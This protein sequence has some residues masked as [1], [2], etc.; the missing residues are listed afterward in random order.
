MKICVAGEGAFGNKHLEAL[1][2]IDGVEVASLVGGVADATEAVAKKYNIPHW[3]LDLAEGLAQPG[4]E[5][6]ILTTPTPLHARQAEQAMR[7]GKHVL[8]EIPMADNIADAE[9]LVQVQKEKGVVAMA[10]HVRRF[11]PSH[12]WVHRKMVAGELKLQQFAATT[13]FFRRTN[14]N[15]LG[16]PRSWTDHLLWHHACHAVDLFLWQ[17][18]EKVIEA[19]AIQGPMHPELGIAMDMAIQLKAASGAIFTLSLSF[20]NNGPLGSF[21]RY[22]CDNGTYIGR[23]DELVDGYDKPIDLTGVGVSLNGVELED[24]EFIAAI[25]EKREPESSLAKCLPTMRVLDRL[26]RQLLGAQAV[27]AE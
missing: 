4:V 9:R 20:N 17:T 15:A 16:Q 21:Y 5:A 12:Q 18:G 22:I 3:T 23:Y 1:A 13:Y 14:L 6:V 26:E 24:R 19:Q 2:K 11:N 7:A 10:G 25:R 8:V 27:A